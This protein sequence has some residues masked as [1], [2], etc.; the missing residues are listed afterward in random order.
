MK[1]G[2]NLAFAAILEPD[3]SEIGMS[4]MFY[5]GKDKERR[6]RKATKMYQFSSCILCLVVGAELKNYEVGG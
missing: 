2:P 6:Q 1:N 4:Q 3:E 5:L